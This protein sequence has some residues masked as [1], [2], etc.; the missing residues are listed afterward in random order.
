MPPGV[1]VKSCS[2]GHEDAEKAGI[3]RYKPALIVELV[4]VDLQRRHGLLVRSAG[5]GLS[6]TV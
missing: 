3:E 4:L 6:S 2:D 1:E 5:N